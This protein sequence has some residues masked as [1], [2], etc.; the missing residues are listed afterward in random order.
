MQRKDFSFLNSSSDFSR[1]CSNASSR[2]DSFSGSS[3][4]LCQDP[5]RSDQVDNRPKLFEFLQDECWSEE[6]A[7]IHLS[8]VPS[9]VFTAPGIKDDRLKPKPTVLQLPPMEETSSI[10]GE[11]LKLSDKI[12]GDH[13]R[14]LKNEKA[15]T[16]S[17]CCFPSLS[18]RRSPR[19]GKKGNPPNWALRMTRWRFSL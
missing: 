19:E 3:S 18:P 2:R 1:S 6:I 17:R 4:V 15:A 12:A 7:S 13:N 8:Y 14:S 10:P 9:A 16:A 5:F 11:E